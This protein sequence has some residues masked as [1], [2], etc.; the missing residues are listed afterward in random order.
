M[1]REPVVGILVDYLSHYGRNVIMGVGRFLRTHERWSLRGE[2]RRVVPPIGNLATWRGD[3]VIA[4]VWDDDRRDRVLALRKRGI[5]V[6]DVGGVIPH[7]PLPQVTPDDVAIGALVA[8]YFITR[9]FRRLGF[10][11]PAG[12]AAA[13]RRLDGFRAR[14][15][16]VGTVVSVFEPRR[17]HRYAG[18]LEADV[19]ELARWVAGLPKPVGL[20]GWHDGRARQIAE[21]CYQIKA[22]VP[23]EVSIVGVDD[24]EINCELGNPP[25]SSVAVAI[26]Q[27]GYQA[28]VMLA[29]LMAG[30]PTPTNI[31]IPPI[32]VVTRR[33]SDSLAVEDSDVVEAMRT[34]R[35]H[36]S[37]PLSVKQLLRMVPISRRQMERQF[38]LHI[39]H[40]PRQEIER[41]HLERA[42]R[43]LSETN[44][45]L[46]RVAGESGYAS[47][48]HFTHVF[49]QKVGQ[50]PGAYRRR[51]SDP[52]TPAR[53]A[54]NIA[55]RRRT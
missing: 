51:F 47:Y 4:Q 33:S 17:L 19:G 46:P 30:K 2:P 32:G 21:A 29:A 5:H 48:E 10:S 3:G 38:K 52:V 42:K 18:G 16:D 24:D 44:W 6:V 13:D 31:L 8:D 28:A 7:L 41:V 35:E 39:G 20:L 37:R 11:G 15:A 9:G 34:I 45:A 27:V 12:H 49:R 40:S 36:A 1:G 23:E 54:C 53:P 50:S 26:E 43:L 14:A 55:P 22:R 25:L